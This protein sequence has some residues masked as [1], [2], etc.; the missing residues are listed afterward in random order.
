MTL[1]DPSDTEKPKR[2]RGMG[3]LGDQLVALAA[4]GEMS[5]LLGDLLLVANAVVERGE[6]NTLNDAM[7]LVFTEMSR[8]ADRVRAVQKQA[9]GDDA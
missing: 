5:K 4:M 8:A 2:P 9:A 7:T 1:R 6:A 3:K